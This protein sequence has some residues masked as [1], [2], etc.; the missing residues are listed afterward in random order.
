MALARADGTPNRFYSLSSQIHA[1]RNDYYDQLEQQQRS[2]PDI[3][4]W[5]EWF[6]ACLGRAVTGAETILNRVIFKAQLWDAVNRK[7][8]N[9]RQRLIINRM[10]EGEFEGHMNTSQYQLPPPGQART[11]SYPVETIT[12][13]RPAPPR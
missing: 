5:L 3:T 6:V 10:L 13:L 7:P 4:G 9:E 8:V 2:T 12:P 1:E 11:V